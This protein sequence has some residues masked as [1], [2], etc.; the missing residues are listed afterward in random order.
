MCVTRRKRIAYL[1]NRA[2][3]PENADMRRLIGG[4]ASLSICLCFAIA[5]PAATTVINFDTPNFVPLPYTESGLTFES[6]I[7]TASHLLGATGKLYASG[8]GGSSPYHIRASSATRFHLQSMEIHAQFQNWRLE[9]STGAV[10]TLASSGPPLP[11]HVDF[12]GT[13][14]WSNID[15][16]DLI[17]DYGGD[18]RHILIDNI[19]VQF[20]PEPSAAT[21]ATV[22]LLSVIRRC[23][24]RGL[25]STVSTWAHAE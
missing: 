23:D 10:M 25:R 13:P 15:S 9:S 21:L 1:G 16:F 8:S 17:H 3:G 4:F 20:V 24:R 6:I 14:G 2:I 7:P 22:V 5:A 19:R 11:I 18:R 12:S